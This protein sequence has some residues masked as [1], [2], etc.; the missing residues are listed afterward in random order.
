ME[1]TLLEVIQDYKDFKARLRSN[2]VN[3]LIPTGTPVLVS[4]AGAYRKLLRNTQW[5]PG[6]V[7]GHW[8]DRIILT[9]VKVNAKQWDENRRYHYCNLSFTPETDPTKEI[10]IKVSRNCV[11]ADRTLLCRLTDRPHHPDFTGNA[12][13]WDFLL[14]R[15]CEY[16]RSLR[17]ESV[18]HG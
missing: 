18:P 11:Q 9:K 12:L 3:Y 15:L 17:K 13:S 1:K 5:I 8:G 4:Y 7:V 10:E 2:L 6:T 16:N 14:E